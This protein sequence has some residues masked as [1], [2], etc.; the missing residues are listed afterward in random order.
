MSLSAD[1]SSGG[2]GETLAE[3]IARR[4]IEDPDAVFL[5]DA[6]SERVIR[7]RDLVELPARAAA[8]GAEAVLIAPEDP[9]DFALVYLAVLA[10]G[11][12]AAPVAPD[13]SAAALET[14]AGQ[15]P[16]SAVVVRALDELPA[17]AHAAPSGERGSAVLFTSGSTGT[18]K[19]V[20][21]SE[22]QLLHVARAVAA[23][24]ELSPEDRGYNPLPLFHI[25]AEVVAL[26]ATLVAGGTLVLDRRFHRTGFWE[27]MRERRV[28]WIN[29]VPAILAILAKEPVEAPRG[30]R[31]IRSASAPL[32][33]PVAAAFDGVPLI[34]SY[35]MTEAASQITATPLDGSAPRGS[36]GRAVGAELEVRDDDGALLPAASVGLIWIRGRGVISHYFGD[37]AAD[38]FDKDGWLRTG[39]L[40]SVDA[41]GFV[42]LVGRSDDVINRGGELVYP[43]DV[44]DVLLGDARVREAVVVAKPDEVLGQVPVAFVIPDGDETDAE[45]LRVALLER[46]AAE[47]P[48][49]LR[50]VELTVTDELPRAATGKVQRARIRAALQEDDA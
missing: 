12:R 37:V 44:E 20:E 13:S 23:H 40:G 26:L 32:P 15:F 27:L 5:E 14:L 21:L 25:N 19:G 30:L 2:D 39:D 22:E 41:D 18:P 38:R 48:R 17:A 34:V 16:G 28:T 3:L 24:N 11:L 33:D 31:F 8:L 7:Y 42:T 43:A 49:H 36:V 50:P 9:I 4:G 29:A 10:A 47:L 6:R 35:G 45:S 46:A 1:G